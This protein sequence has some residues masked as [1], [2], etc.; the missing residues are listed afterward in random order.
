MWINDLLTDNDT[1]QFSGF[2]MLGMDEFRETKH[3][4]WD[5]E[6]GVKPWWSPYGKK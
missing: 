5:F 4:H 2:K 3:A 6:S 1:G